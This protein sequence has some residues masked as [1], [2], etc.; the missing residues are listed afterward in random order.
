VQR[1]IRGLVVAASVVVLTATTLAVAA[2]AEADTRT[3]LF[4]DC[5]GP[6]GTP[7]SFTAVKT[8]IPEA[9]A[10]LTSSAA[11]FRLVDHSG[12]YNVLSFGEGNFSPPGISSSAAGRVVCSVDF[13]IGTT[14]VTGNL[15]PA[16]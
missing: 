9:T 15:A 1:L 7:V 3:Y 11:A 10:K 6:A 14:Q 16:S 12:I 2:G 4:Y 8:A 13:T 5:S